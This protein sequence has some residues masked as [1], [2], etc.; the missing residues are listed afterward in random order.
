MKH[1]LGRWPTWGADAGLVV[2]ALA[3]PLV[4]QV[5]TDTTDA[6]W[7]WFAVCGAVAGASVVA[8]R[9][10]PATAFVAALGTL[11]A[12]LV[13]SS[14]EG[15]ELTPLVLLPLAVLLHGLGSRCAG[16][17]RTVL[18]VG[19]GS[20]MVLAGLSVDRLAVGAGGFDVL[21]VLALM[22]LAWATGFAA[23]TRREL[24]AAAGERAAE[25]TR[26]R[27]LREEQA[28]LRERARI[29]REMHDVAAHSLTLL[30][31]HAE[32]LRARGGE[33]PA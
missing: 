28:A 8:G 4:S 9:R 23:R 7:A 33:L 22:P 24:L 3:P 1:I 12:A 18:A 15:V 19:A 26:A 20:V 10:L 5:Y 25:A 27:R 21:S 32:T 17:R 16:W 11:V 14:L 2:L 30:V 31:V 13:G 29:A 6:A